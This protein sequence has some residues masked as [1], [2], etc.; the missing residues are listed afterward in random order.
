MNHR[1]VDWK[2][3]RDV[4]QRL[5]EAEHLS[6]EDAFICADNLVDADLTG[7]ESHGVSRLKNYM[8]R[9]STGVVSATGEITV[10]QEHAA[11]L[12]ID[13][14]NTMGMVSSAFAMKRCIEKAKESGSC[15]A[16]VK[17]SNHY[18]MAA[19]YV[20][21]ATEA[22]MV[23]ITGTNAPPNLAPWGSS[24]KYMGTNPIAFGAPTRTRPI[25][26]DMAPSVVAMGK[27]I[28]AAKLGKTIPEG[29]VVDQQGNPTTDPVIG[30]YGT[31]L[32]IGGAKGS[33]LAIFGEILSGVLSGSKW[34][35]HINNFWSDFENPQDVG[36]FFLA[37]DI[38]KFI[39][40]EAYLSRI[41]Q[42]VD[43]IKGL[44]KSPDADEIFMPGEIEIRKR[45]ERKRDGI[46]LAESVYAELAELAQTYNVEFT[47]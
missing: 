27:I 19:Y 33:G 43:E 1:L 9:L 8:K 6:Q 35:P 47:L 17:G 32:P 34:G 46:Q 5:L 4:C 23:A 3:L 37:V 24:Q 44:P 28:L 36:H 18:G 7:V 39:E 16:T 38:E 13:G 21:M 14:G 29:W 41:T 26:L 15:F 12:A 2:A 30:Q 11:S 31:L 42:L 10:L 40:Y 22:G 25:I 20:A 45:E